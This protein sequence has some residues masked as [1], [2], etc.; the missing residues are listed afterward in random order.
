MK[1]EI[2]L[3]SMQDVAEEVKGKEE[4]GGGVKDEIVHF[5][6]QNVAEEGKEEGEGVE[7]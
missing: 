5:S 4:G 2:V 7:K 6:L 1:D 3:F